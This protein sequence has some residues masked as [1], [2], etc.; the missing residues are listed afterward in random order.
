MESARFDRLARSF[1]TRTSRR[2]ATAAAIA[3][4]FGG[5]RSALANQLTPSTCGAAGDVC[6][7]LMGCCDGLTC[8]TSAINTNYG[9]CV[10]GEGG[11]VSI[12]TTLISPFSENVEQE[13]AAIAAAETTSTTTTTVDPEADREQ[14]I[15]E[16][17]S[18]RS[19]RR[20]ERD[21]RRSTNKSQ[22]EDRR[23]DRRLNREL[24]RGPKLVLE[25]FN[26]GGLNASKQ[27]A[28]ETVR[29]TNRDD[30]DVTLHRI[31]SLPPPGGVAEVKVGTTN[32]YVLDPGE[33]F[34]F[35]SRS[36]PDP[37]SLDG[38]RFSW[39]GAP[40]CQG[41]DPKEGF[42]ISASRGISFEEH[43]YTVLC[44]SSTSGNE[45]GGGKRRK[46]RR[47]QNGGNNKNRNRNR[48]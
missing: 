22:K 9:V 13:V 6:T 25:V 18:R 43:P 24:R 17:K 47:K 44:N 4:T 14:V 15:A 30:Q 5:G 33:S 45:N 8:V 21:T 3:L 31:E 10:A 11:T 32:G 26:P 41:L 42:L 28:V 37:N 20:S 23:D 7:M 35:L 39:I 40:V 1:A 29:V 36:T 46:R 38:N 16:R 19:A 12:G 2:T 34:L 27:P 48:G